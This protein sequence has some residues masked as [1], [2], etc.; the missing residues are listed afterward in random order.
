MRLRRVR[1]PTFSELNRHGKKGLSFILALPFASTAPN[2]FFQ[3]SS[4]STD[5]KQRKKKVLEAGTKR[6]PR[7]STTGGLVISTIPSARAGTGFPR[8]VK[9]NSRPAAG[10]RGSGFGVAVLCSHL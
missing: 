5:A 2:D 3:P 10:S 1:S 6:S 8:V 9:Q 7:R 4:Y